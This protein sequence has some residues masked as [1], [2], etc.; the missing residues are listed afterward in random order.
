MRP[1]HLS[2]PSAA[3]THEPSHQPHRGLGL[4][5]QVAG[6]HCRAG[7]RREEGEG[8]R[9]GRQQEQLRPERGGRASQVRA[10]GVRRGAAGAAHVHGGK[11]RDAKARGLR[12]AHLPPAGRLVASEQPGAAALWRRRRSEG[13]QGDLPSLADAARRGPHRGLELHRRAR[14]RLL[15]HPLPPRPVEGGQVAR[16]AR[17]GDRGG[18]DATLA[19]PRHNLLG[20]AVRRLG[21][22]LRASLAAERRGLGAVPPLVRADVLCRRVVGRVAA[23][24]HL[25]LP[26]AHPIDVERGPDRPA[27]GGRVDCAVA[28]VPRPD[29]GVDDERHRLAREGARGRA[30]APARRLPARLPPRLARPMRRGVDRI[31]AEGRLV[32]APDQ[33][34]VEQPPK[35]AALAAAAAEEL[36]AVG[37]V[38]LVEDV[39]DDRGRD[40]VGA[41]R[42]ARGAPR[43]PVPPL[44]SDAVA[45]L[46]ARVPAAGAAL[47]REG[48]DGGLEVGRHRGRDLEREDG[49]RRCGR[50]PDGHLGRVDLGRASAL[51]RK[52]PVDIEVVV[53]ARADSLRRRVWRQGEVGVALVVRPRP[54]A[55]VGALVHG[56]AEVAKQPERRPVAASVRHAR[57]ELDDA[58]GEAKLIPRLE[59]RRAE[60]HRDLTRA[61]RVRAG[62]ALV[63]GGDAQRRHARLLWVERHGRLL[64]QVHRL[65]LV[66][67]VGDVER[68]PLGILAVCKRAA[69]IVELVREDEPVERESRPR[70]CRPAGRRRGEVAPAAGGERGGVHRP[71]R[72]SLAIRLCLAASQLH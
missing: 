35:R 51:E 54:E 55:R 57:A 70:R 5:A 19:R 10:R 16:P 53:V 27:G 68:R 30:L 38:A 2:S 61:A 22:D 66:G 41:A 44:A 23:D 59:H 60:R 45:V 40:R 49:V 25:R 36:D 4:A 3:H 18:R 14:L 72:R 6:R 29:G 43:R 33:P 37:A 20:V 62:R 42:R 17:R 21:V 65:A 9:V 7:N 46:E 26:H 50:R 13:R 67:G 56:A 69:W 52:E 31:R 28:P 1:R 48:A 71:A 58:A 11:A 12:P 8:A 64:R 24:V 15:H 34:P 63:H 39:V 47:R 32:E